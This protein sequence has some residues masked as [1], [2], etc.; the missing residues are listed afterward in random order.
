M[1]VCYDN[2]T[3][4]FDHSLSGVIQIILDSFESYKQYDIK[5]T[6]GNDLKFEFCKHDYLNGVEFDDNWNI[7]KE[8]EFIEG[9]TYLIKI[10]HDLI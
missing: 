7:N 3:N 9:I 8:Y 2:K 5:F 6:A 4:I 10:K 1:Y